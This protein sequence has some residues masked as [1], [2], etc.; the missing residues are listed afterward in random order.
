MNKATEERLGSLNPNA[1]DL[2]DGLARCLNL[3]CT[4]AVAAVLEKAKDLRGLTP[5]Q[6]NERSIT[7]LLPVLEFL[8][9]RLRGG[10]GVLPMQSLKSFAELT[11][12]LCLED[13]PGDK[14]YAVR[15]R[16]LVKIA[17]LDDFR[18]LLGTMWAC[19]P[20]CFSKL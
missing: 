7:V 11:T 5:K 1:R 12:S 10:P 6:I 18:D 17:I 20:L 15:V 9:D 16:S 2:R 19:N 13:I 4:D 14:I 8:C 3:R